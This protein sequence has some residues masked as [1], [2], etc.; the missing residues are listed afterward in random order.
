MS[1]T[2]FVELLQFIKKNNSWGADMYDICQVRNRRAI[3]YVDA[4]FDSRDGSI[5][6]IA[7]R[8][9]I[10]HK[11]ISFRVDTQEDVDKIYQFLN[12][13]WVKERSVVID[14]QG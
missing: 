14:E 12:E 10:G 9:I 8:Q 3:K 1:P 7:F 11:E 6:R 13:P 2:Q 5:W 4:S